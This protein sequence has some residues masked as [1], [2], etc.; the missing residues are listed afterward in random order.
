MANLYASE[1]WA[2]FRAK[3]IALDGGECVACGRSVS[4]GVVLQVHHKLYI[5]GR[6]PWEYEPFD[7]ETLCRGCH[8]REHGELRPNTGWEYV[9]EDDL[10][11]LVG[12]CELCG[13]AIRYVHYAQHKHWEQM[14]VGTDCC[15]SLTGT[16][17]ATE[18]RRKMG[19]FRRFMSSERWHPDARGQR[20]NYKGFKVVVVM[21]GNSCTLQINGV[22]GH[23]L[24]ENLAAAQRYL[25]DFIDEGDAREYFQNKAAI[26]KDGK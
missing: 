15:D 16:Q 6:K 5:S 10:G 14:G 11:D 8:A 23:R 4:D 7:C 17:E 24:H 1:K 9:G 22:K 19:R 3:V 2:N 12:S 26:K 25:F 13:A 20:T 18:A 21:E